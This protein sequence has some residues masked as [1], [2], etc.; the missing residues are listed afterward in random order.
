MENTC[1]NR[2]ESNK[3]K[4]FYIYFSHIGHMIPHDKE[5]SKDY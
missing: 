2:I 4:R 1:N 5:G 3:K